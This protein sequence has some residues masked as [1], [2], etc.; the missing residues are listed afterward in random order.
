MLYYVKNYVISL[1]ESQIIFYPPLW[2]FL[3]IQCGK[4]SSY[5]D[6]NKFQMIKFSLMIYNSVFSLKDYYLNFLKGQ[7]ED[8]IFAV[9]PEAA[10]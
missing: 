10:F 5:N 1:Q 6:R 8:R 7:M 2:K 3:Y 4:F 9:R